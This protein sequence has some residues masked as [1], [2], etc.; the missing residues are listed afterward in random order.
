M[1]RHTPNTYTFPRRQNKN[2]SDL[3]FF[4]CGILWKTDVVKN[5]M[6]RKTTI[7]PKSCS[8]KVYFLMNILHR[9]L[10]IDKYVIR[11]LLLSAVEVTT[12]HGHQGAVS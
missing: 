11:K 2:I 10:E 3:I 12:E 7:I 4:F 1:S 5:N 8:D 6:Q 9:F